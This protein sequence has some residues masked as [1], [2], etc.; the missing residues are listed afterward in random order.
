MALDA[1][2][3]YSPQDSIQEDASQQ[4]RPR[5]QLPPFTTADLQNKNNAPL[6]RAV[7]EFAANLA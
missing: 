1:P 7:P 5:S 4:E 3:F 2:P 6:L